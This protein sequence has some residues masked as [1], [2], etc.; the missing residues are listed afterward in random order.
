MRLWRSFVSTHRFDAAKSIEGMEI[1]HRSESVNLYHCCVHKTGS[2][3]IRNILSDPIVYKYSGLK[4][5]HYQSSLAGGNDSR[6]ISQRTF[7]EAFPR[8]TIVS[9]LYI[10]FGSFTTVPKPEKYKGFFVMRDPRD[11][12]I[13]WYFSMRHSHTVLENVRKVRETLDGMSFHDGILLAMDHLNTSGH[14]QV[15]DSW[16]D[17]P[18]TDPNVLLVRF[19]DLIGLASENVF[20]ELFRHCDIRMP[21]KQLCK[22]LTKYS[23]R[24]LSG[25]PPGQEDIKHHYRK[26]IIGDWRNHLSDTLA[27][28]FKEVAGTLVSRLGYAE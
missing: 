16:V 11:I 18:R 26:G 5:Y 7:A 2:Q 4:G 1:A 23:F 19:E 21:R 10:P 14:F 8:L 9:P 28:R 25:R 22:L 15:L 20:E 24:A 6:D 12:L 3:W 17:A 13:S 27:T